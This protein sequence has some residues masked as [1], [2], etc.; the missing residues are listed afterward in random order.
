MSIGN[1]TMMTETRELTL[2][3]IDEVES[4]VAKK[5]ARGIIALISFIRT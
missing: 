1:K 2:K 3:I 4:Y 5:R